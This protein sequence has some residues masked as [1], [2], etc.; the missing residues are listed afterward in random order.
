MVVLQDIYFVHFVFPT[1][2]FSSSMQASFKALRFYN[3]FS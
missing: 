3:V 1:D 2:R